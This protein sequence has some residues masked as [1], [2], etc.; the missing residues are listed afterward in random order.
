MTLWCLILIIQPLLIKNRKNDLHKL[1]GKISYLVF[2]FLVYSICLV[3]LYSFERMKSHVSLV[4]LDENISQIFLPISQLF[5]FTIFYVLAMLNKRKVKIH[6]RYI[7]VSSVALFG[8][9]IGRIDFGLDYFNADLWFMDICIL[10]FLIYDMFYDKKYK[11]YLIGLF[12]FII[13]HIANVW[14]ANSVFW[15]TIAKNILHN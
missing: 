12:F 13:I 6:M 9:T 10:G 5:L 8:P 7:I 1:I 4:S 14:F 11:P 2:P 15:S 3:I